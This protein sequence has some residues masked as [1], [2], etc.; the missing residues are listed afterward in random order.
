MVTVEYQKGQD[1]YLIQTGKYDH[2]GPS[3]IALSPDGRT[4]AIATTYNISM[5]NATTAE[6]AQTF[7]NVHSSKLSTLL[8]NSYTEYSFPSYS[9]LTFLFLSTATD[10]SN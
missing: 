1:P 5:Y 4:V 3:L 2:S 6:L 8:F 10:I 7:E 9:L